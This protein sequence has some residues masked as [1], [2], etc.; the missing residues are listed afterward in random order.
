MR[1]VGQQLTAVIP[2]LEDIPC[3]LIPTQSR[4]SGNVHMLFATQQ[5]EITQGRISC[6]EAVDIILAA[7]SDGGGR[8]SSMPPSRIPVVLQGLLP[9][10]ERLEIEQVV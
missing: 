7:H 5:L 8:S 9:G 4:N 2:S 3:E 1:A 6:L 10:D